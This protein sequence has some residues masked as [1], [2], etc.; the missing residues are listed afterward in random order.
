MS[1]KK[2]LPVGDKELPCFV[3]L[4]K[5]GKVRFGVGVWGAAGGIFFYINIHAVNP[6]LPFV[7]GMWVFFSFG[8]PTQRPKIY[9]LFYTK[10]PDKSAANR[11]HPA[12]C[13]VKHFLYVE[14]LLH[15]AKTCRFLVEKNR[16]R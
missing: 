12:E 11:V 3:S 14:S 4:P 2:I 13:P 6:H 16:N 1:Y 8:Q 9:I 10:N 15:D 7:C 5:G